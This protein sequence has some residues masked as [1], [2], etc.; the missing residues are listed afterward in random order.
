M[1]IWICLR[2]HLSCRVCIFIL[3]EYKYIWIYIDI[4]TRRY[5]L[6]CRVCIFIFSSMHMIMYT[7]TRT[8]ACARVYICIHISI[9]THTYMY[10]Y[11]SMCVCARCHGSLAHSTV[12]LFFW[13]LL[14]FDVCV[15]WYVHVCWC[16]RYIPSMLL[17]FRW[18]VDTFVYELLCMEC[19]HIPYMECVHTCGYI[20]CCLIWNVR[21]VPTHSHI[22]NVR[23]HSIYG[24]CTCMYT[25]QCMY[26]F[27]IWN[28]Y[29]TILP[30]YML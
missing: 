16:V 9:Y 24:M 26:T 1:K 19:L 11:I 20:A 8:Y 27:R 12:F 25:F 5:H 23:T 15:C 13:T 28:V 7:H 3:Y 29:A 6:S 17:P 30:T 4:Y 21:N 22:C 18:C 2:Y 10:I 14:S